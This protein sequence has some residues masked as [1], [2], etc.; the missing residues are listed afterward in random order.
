MTDI[1]KGKIHVLQSRG[2]GYKKIAAELDLSVNSVKS[3]CRRHP[4]VE[5]EEPGMPRCLQCGAAVEQKE[6]RKQKKFCSDQCRSAW[7]KE[8][9]DQIKRTKLISYICPQCGDGFESRNHGRIYCSRSC[10]AQARSKEVA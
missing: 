8:H 4:V 2:Y 1:E 7:W 3:Y 9:P 10:Y 5:V 6:Q